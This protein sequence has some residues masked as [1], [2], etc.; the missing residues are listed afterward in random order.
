MPELPPSTRKRQSRQLPHGT[1]TLPDADKGS[2]TCA[3]ALRPA[4]QRKQVSTSRSLAS[5]LF[6]SPETR[7]AVRSTVAPANE[8]E[9][10]LCANAGP[11]SPLPR[12]RSGVPQISRAGLRSPRRRDPLSAGWGALRPRRTARLR[13]RRFRP[14]LAALSGSLVHPGGGS[15][16][17][18]RRCPVWRPEPAL[19]HPSDD[20]A[21]RQRAAVAHA[22]RPERERR[23]RRS[24]HARRLLR[25]LP[26]SL[27]QPGLDPLP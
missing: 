8:P 17:D 12:E 19:L 18:E 13:S 10:L 2:P 5:R 22:A 11:R 23:Q 3:S 9:G 15:R 21:V 25:Q 27:G 6:A 16:P 24:R 26:D 4:R 14:P 20:G 7:S 1:T